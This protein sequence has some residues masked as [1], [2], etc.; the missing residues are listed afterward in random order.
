M[1]E[2]T[3]ELQRRIDLLEERIARLNAAALRINSSLDLDKVLQEV[4]DSARILTTAHYGIIITVDPN[5]E[6]EEFVTSGF[7]RAEKDQLA[8]WPQG[9]LLFEHFRDLRASVRLSDLP[10]Y[11][12]DRGFSSQLMRAK[13][14][15]GTPLHYRDVS[16]GN[17]FIAGKADDQEFTAADEDILM[18][19]ASQ[20]ATAIANA[21]THRNEQRARADLETLIDTSPVGVV[22]FD[23]KTAKPTSFNREVSR[24]VSELQSPD[25]SPEEL[26]DDITCR[27][28]D[29]RD[30]SLTEFPMSRQLSDPETIHAEEITLSV[31]DGRNVTMLVNTTP[32]RSA[33]GAVESMVVILQDLTPLEELARIRAEILGKVSD[34]LRTPLIAIKGASASALSADPRPDQHE[35]HQYFRV[36]DQKVDQ[37]RAL[38][39]DLL[40]YGRI[41]TGTL[42]MHPVTIDV[43][44][45]VEQGCAKFRSEYKNRSIKV[46]ISEDV[47]DV[48]VDPS[49]IE[50]TID[51]LL[52][53]ISRFS[54]SSE[55]IEISV[56]REDVHVAVRLTARNW[57]VPSKQL[58]HLFQRYSPPNNGEDGFIS[59][60]AGIDLAICR[61]LVEANGGRIWAEPDASIDGAQ[62][63]FTLPVAYD[64][65]TTATQTPSLPSRTSINRQRATKDRILVI[66][67]H[68]Q[69]QQYIRESL[70]T[71]EFET[72]FTGD[73]EQLEDV[74]ESF[75][76]ELVILDLQQ[77]GF[78]PHNKIA[79]LSGNLDVPLIFIA[80]D[81]MDETVVTA[82]EAGA[83][84]YV[85]K[86]FSPS[87]LV[88]RVRGALR[89]QVL[90]LPFVL[91]ELQIDYEHRNVQVGAQ[92]V[93]LTATEYELLRVLSTN[94]GRVMNYAILL[95]QVWGKR[96][97]TS[98][99]TKAVRAVVKRLRNK[100]GDDAS[101]PTYIC[102]ERGVGYFVPSVGDA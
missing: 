43:K 83:D 48:Q 88:A 40:E 5:G 62:I 50:Q 90:P 94:A 49:R 91:G 86:P 96:N 42:E 20:A 10:A 99:D 55:A 17:F 46:D 68:P 97:Q 2:N 47:P 35:M 102:N 61:G 92:P 30:V 23:G 65:R 53:F 25:Q 56:S 7:T 24:I 44:T 19:F 87:E 51:H 1:E 39:R 81:G 57:N 11:V 71:T 45:L 89:R 69:M 37:M 28:A 27:R 54:E 74:I 52:T 77:Q 38:I 67:A 31:P 6:V 41:A 70:A 85:I 3:V 75:D 80:P 29:G 98:D 32:I 21:R 64:A 93:E 78:A 60:V 12:R 79:Q 8:E 58:T 33:D 4:V 15:L 76:P 14:F 73:G 13:T 22:V 95:R 82:L 9:P 59:N 63:S 36:I 72:Q 34:E 18:T 101:T 100:L 26:L 84:D 16:V 66:D